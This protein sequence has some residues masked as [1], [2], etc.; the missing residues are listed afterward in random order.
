[1][2]YEQ[3]AVIYFKQINGHSKNAHDCGI[4]KYDC[5]WD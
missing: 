2:K 1:M 3:Y 5:D 4:L